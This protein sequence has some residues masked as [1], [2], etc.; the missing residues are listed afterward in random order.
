[1]DTGPS[2]SRAT[3]AQTRC[4][5]S[6]SPRVAAL[7]IWLCLSACCAV[8]TA[9]PQESERSSQV[10]DKPT[11]SL[12]DV[13]ARL[14]EVDATELDDATK[15]QVKEAY[16]KAKSA[17]EQASTSAKESAKYKSWIA[18]AEQDTE[19]IVQGKEKPKV[20][21]ISRAEFLKLGE[22]T[23]E[24]SDLENQLNGLK[25]DLEQAQA[26]PQRR[27]QRID[28]IPGEI[29]KAQNDLDSVNELF[30]AAATADDDAVT[31]A[32]RTSLQAQKQQLVALI[33][34]LQN[35]QA[36]YDAQG[37]LPRLRIDQLK[38][39]IAQTESDY[40][41][42][43][44]EVTDARRS[45]ATQQQND[46]N[47]AMKAA[48][49]EFKPLAKTIVGLTALR[50]KIAEAML[51]A[52]RAREEAS[53]ELVRWQED[54]ERTKKR[55]EDA[56]ESFGLTLVRKRTELP[57]AATLATNV[58]SL[59]GELD[60]YR[61]RLYELEDRRALLSDPKL[62]ASTTLQQLGEFPD[63]LPEPLETELASLLTLET[64]ILDSL[65]KDMKRNY[66]LRVGVR[67]DK[68]RLIE[69]V[70]DYRAHI[71]GRLFW[72]K[73]ARPLG[74]SDLADSRNAVA[75]LFNRETLSSA[76]YQLRRNV[77]NRPLFSISVLTLVVLIF[78][79][80][81]RLKRKLEQM[82]DEA[83]RVSCRQLSP[84]MRAI[85]LS[86]V[87]SLAWPLPILFVAWAIADSEVEQLQGFS[88]AGYV[89]FWWWLT[90][91]FLRQVWRYKGLAVCHFGWSRLQSAPLK[92]CLLGLVIAGAPLLFFASVFLHHGTLEYR[93][94]LGRISL[95][96][97]LL[98]VSW[99]LVRLYRGIVESDGDQPTF[100][101][102]HRRKLQWVSVLA[103]FALA[104]FAAIGYQY[105]AYELTLDLLYSFWLIVSLIVVQAVLFRAVR[106]Q[107]RKIRWAQ[108]IESRRSAGTSEESAA[109]DFDAILAK[110][111][112][113]DLVA[114]D[115]QTRR[116]ITFLVCIAAAYGMAI[117]GAE[118]YP[119]LEPLAKQPINPFFQE[120]GIKQ[121]ITI[122]ALATSIL[123]I[124]LTVIAWR[125]LPG[126]VDVL[127]LGRLGVESSIRYAVT[128]ISQYL[129]GIAGVVSSCAAVRIGWDQVQ[130]L[131]AAMGVGLGF[132]LQEIVAN[133]ICG[134]LL[135]FERPIRVGD[136]VSLGDTT[137]VVIRIRTRA[138]TVRN[139]DRQE[140]VIP[141]KELITG[142]IT[143]WTLSDDMNRI[144]V[145]VGVAYGSDTEKAREIL[146][147]L[148][149]DDPNVLDDPRPLITF[150]QFG[151]S[152][153]NF[154]V[155]AYLENMDERTET[156]HQVHT[157]IYQRFAEADIEIAFPQLD[158]H[159]RSN[160]ASN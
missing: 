35:E 58:R 91:D 112:E 89:V 70:S 38:A 54:F 134:V 80:R 75:W 15:A 36:A 47:A 142:R 153:L 8:A 3:S 27:V 20:Y 56:S 48:P 150:E 18:N 16:T 60:V 24:L 114:M 11:V 123:L 96:G 99:T 97:L 127:L 62:A 33:Q 9:Q 119:A 122:G 76:T 140:V 111:G 81:S 17:L 135:L 51:R 85:F 151:D 92:S 79:L 137:G 1:M 45:D 43:F 25:Q 117:I 59:N 101:H 67:D 105:T 66:G 131:V 116:L 152:T 94:S 129:I 87:L 10:E 160:V 5:W 157:A 52:A 98:L 44:E 86:A 21:E 53:R 148:L 22:L 110:E 109:S 126:L 32:Q 124:T 40:L 73:S 88:E 120:D 138:T 68:E 125:N 83:A 132:G 41:T 118:L 78:V 37:E 115:R 49:D 107:R 23:K 102:R 106:I 130:F 133:F 95:I 77:R 7:G 34:S 141:N 136:I 61:E 84:T 72:L 12:E 146:R 64:R 156:I 144:T 108:L 69:I 103:P 71:D 155:R 6:F 2:S 50:K 143:N 90:L 14:K 158:V 57:S 13:L 63:P 4:R 26:E 113:T 93:D 104:V 29:A 74:P 19:T 145:N 100:W 65:L 46:A 39:Q 28:R 55:S 147:D 149:A 42:L 121:P 30:R 82:G 128:T 159:V 31:V 139:W 154:V